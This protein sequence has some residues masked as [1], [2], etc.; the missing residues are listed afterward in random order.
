MV[1][2][3]TK[4]RTNRL[5]NWGHILTNLDVVHLLD[6]EQVY[7]LHAAPAFAHTSYPDSYS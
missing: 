3:T 5:L 1:D 6:D 4:V 7:S 2:L